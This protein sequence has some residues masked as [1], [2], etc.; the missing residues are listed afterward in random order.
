MIHASGYNAD[1]ITWD[2]EE[3]CQQIWP[4]CYV[5]KC[6]FFYFCIFWT[7]SNILACKFVNCEFFP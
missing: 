7:K 1:C 2:L 4:L 3:I 5:Q 6:Y